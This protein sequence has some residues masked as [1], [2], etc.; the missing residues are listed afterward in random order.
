MTDL[1]AQLMAEMETYFADDRRR[2][3]HAHSVTDFAGR[4]LEAEGGNYGIVIAASILHDIGIHEAERK[5]G[6]TSGRY[7]EIEGPPI[8][9][10]ILGRLGFEPER[11]DEIC[12]IIG[13]HHSPGQ[14]NTANFR[15]LYDANWLVNLRDEFDISDTKKL[16]TIIDRVFL[17]ES[18]KRLAREMYLR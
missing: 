17:T 13:H 3:T 16:T 10:G 14:V 2:I 18:G 7:Q 5:Y 12:E 9:R 15:I 1:K 4:L 8:A 11:I 6:S